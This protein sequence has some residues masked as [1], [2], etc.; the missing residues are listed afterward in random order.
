[1]IANNKLRLVPLAI[2]TLAL[3]PR[4]FV[5]ATDERTFQEAS[6]QV[7]SDKA[8]YVR[9]I[10]KSGLTDERKIVSLRQVFHVG[11]S[12]NEVE[13]IWGR[14]RCYMLCSLPT[15]QSICYL[16]NALPGTDTSLHVS[17]GKSGASSFEFRDKQGKSLVGIIQ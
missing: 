5:S 17:Y 13:S 7:L 12:E 2:L 8:E 1:M 3:S 16:Y 11:M 4:N 6:T 10:L 9:H 15:G 14:A